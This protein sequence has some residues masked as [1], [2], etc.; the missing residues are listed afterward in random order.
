MYIA[1]FLSAW[2]LYEITSARIRPLSVQLTQT[3]DGS[4]VLSRFVSTLF[5]GTSIVA[6][7]TIQQRNHFM[8]LG[9]LLI[10][11]GLFMGIADVCALY[12]L[13]RKKQEVDSFI[14]KG[15]DS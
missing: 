2:W 13:K 4:V 6:A 7:S 12:W 15:K 1:F 8:Y 9:L 5:V 11:W 3:F 10:A 14:T